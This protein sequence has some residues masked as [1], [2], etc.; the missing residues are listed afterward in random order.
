MTNG[1]DCNKKNSESSSSKGKLIYAIS[2]DN[3]LACRLLKIK[4]L[5][6]VDTRKHIDMFLSCLAITFEEYL[7]WYLQIHRIAFLLCE[8]KNVLVTFKDI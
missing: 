3:V 7:V 6:G 8:D 1:N 4:S 2:C 5:I